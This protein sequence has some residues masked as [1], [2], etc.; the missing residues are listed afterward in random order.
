MKRGYE[1]QN[2]EL[3]NKKIK[4]DFEKLKR[5]QPEKLKNSLN[6]SWSNW[7]FGMESQEL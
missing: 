4:N 5:E 1:M 2:Y 3:K 6:L 7:G